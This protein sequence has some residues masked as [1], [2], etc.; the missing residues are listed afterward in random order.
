MTDATPVT[1]ATPSAAGT[2]VSP[3]EV[4]KLEM[5]DVVMVGIGAAGGIASYVLTAAGLK[6]VAI[7]AGPRLGVKEF[8]AHADELQS[9]WRWDGEPKFNKEMPTW[10]RSPDEKAEVYASGAKMSNMVG[11]TSV[12][13]AAVSY[14]FLEYDF[15][16]RSSIIERYGEE[17]LPKGTAIA[18][19]AITYDE[20]EP[21]YENVE[22]L[23][24]VSGKG[25]E[26][27]FEAPRKSD[28]P[29]PPLQSFGG[30]DYLAE[31][32]ADL[33]Y[34]PYR[35][36]AGIISKDYDGRPACT[37]CGYCGSY[38]CW[39]N[40]KS[41]TLVSAIPHAE[42]TGNLEIRTNSRV[43]RVLTDDS[44]RASGVEYR[45]D[46]GQMYIQ[47]AKLVIL[48]AYTF[49]NIRLL[50]LS[51][52]DQFPSGLAN[53]AG[54]VGKHYISHTTLFAFGVFPGKNFNRFSGS[55]AQG[56][57]MDD[58]YGDNFD[59]SDL[60]FVSG[61]D[62]QTFPAESNP[63]GASRQIAPSVPQWGSD[64]ANW[65]HENAN[66]VLEVEYHIE[67]LPYEGNYID[68]DPDHVDEDG[69]PVIRF[70][71]DIGENEQRISEYVGT[72]VEEL[73]THR[74]ATETWR[75]KANPSPMSTH[76]VGGARA[77]DDPETCVLDKHLLT[78][79]IPNLA[80]LGG[81]GFASISGHNPTE[82]IEAWAWL[83]AEHIAE[84]FD[85]IV[86]SEA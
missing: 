57:S 76:D 66:S 52:N 65:L 2:P 20:L 30:A 63:I 35:T 29:L 44:G 3:G 22:K 43:F 41:S 16:E 85:S 47:P 67:T 26:N 39:N 54:Q 50:L 40:A 6:V 72:K 49:E 23:I 59:H 11:G 74:G 12:H 75:G 77:G 60:D 17:K 82:T 55:R 42:K 73:L 21:Y 80:V 71:Y 8:L 15:K 36:P 33:G 4:T 81:A 13:Y 86:N 5:T 28:Y 14:R 1:N 25:G 51:A 62:V 46:D 83:A 61:A 37:L 38:E 27:P 79:E 19:W 64:Y 53:N 56:F 24:G 9:S 7:E 45:G 84:N 70:T 32:M 31:T 78:H 48:S 68:L 10:R 69:V 34:H 18:D 58:F